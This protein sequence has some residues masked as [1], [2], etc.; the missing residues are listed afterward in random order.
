[1]G[2]GGG[3]GGVVTLHPPKRN[4]Q[5]L[6]QTNAEASNVLRGSFIVKGPKSSQKHCKFNYYYIGSALVV[7]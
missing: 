6:L 7:W 1:M 4:A 3:G 2:W 5:V